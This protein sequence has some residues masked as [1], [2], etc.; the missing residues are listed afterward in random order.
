ML[1]DS[2]GNTYTTYITRDDITSVRG[3][4]YNDAISDGILEIIFITF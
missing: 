1:K 4:T 3:Y 2:E